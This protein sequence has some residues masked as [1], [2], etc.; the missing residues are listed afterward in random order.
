MQAVVLTYT[1]TQAPAQQTE[2]RYYLEADVMNMMTK[3]V[4]MAL[5]S[6]PRPVQVN[7]SQ[8]AE[9]LGV[10]RPTVQALIRAGTLRLNS[11]GLIPI[12][13]I[14]RALAIREGK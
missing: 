11:C 1:P 5:E 2:Q 9:M 13:E 7:Q 3:A 6:H 8:A 14:D 4:R 12:G 10:S